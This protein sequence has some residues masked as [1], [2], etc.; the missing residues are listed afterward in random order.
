MLWTSVLVS[1]PSHLQPLAGQHLDLPKFLWRALPQ[2]DWPITNRLLAL[3]NKVSWGR[4]PVNGFSDARVDTPATFRPR[5]A[6]HLELDFLS[7]SSMYTPVAVAHLSRLTTRKY[8]RTAVR[9]QAIMACPSGHPAEQDDPLCE[10]PLKRGCAAAVKL[11]LPQKI[12]KLGRWRNFH[13][14]RKLR[15]RLPSRA[16]S[17]L[18]QARCSSSM[19]LARA[20]SQAARSCLR[21]LSGAT[22]SLGM[23]CRNE[24]RTGICTAAAWSSHVHTSCLRFDHPCWPYVIYLPMEATLGENGL[25]RTCSYSSTLMACRRRIFCGTQHPT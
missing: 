23:R 20:C 12:Q 1:T 2:P 7:A 11:G 13:S 3:S 25:L 14:F 6:R 22:V 4:T 15:L 18:L 17:I 10:R 24:T 16:C 9:V 5:S 19:H 21:S 8:S